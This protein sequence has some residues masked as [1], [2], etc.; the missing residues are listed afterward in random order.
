MT[1]TVSLKD[2][3]SLSVS[4]SKITNRF[5]DFEKKS[6]TKA[7]KLLLKLIHLFAR[8]VLSVKSWKSKARSKQVVL[9]LAFQILERLM[10]SNSIAKIKIMYTPVFVTLHFQNIKKM[11][12]ESLE[13][14]VVFSLEIVI[15]LVFTN[16][17]AST[18]YSIFRFTFAKE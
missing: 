9:K 2:F 4:F 7:K 13:L 6:I 16:K 17:I 5:H 15:S 11:K 18:K 3:R 8:E 14:N 12:N 1:H 10:D